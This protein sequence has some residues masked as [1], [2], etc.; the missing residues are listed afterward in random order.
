MKKHKQLQYNLL[1]SV[2]FFT[3]V[4]S[5]L[6]FTG[7]ESA[8]VDTPSHQTSSEKLPLNS[9]IFAPQTSTATS[10]V[11]KPALLQKKSLLSLKK[12][13]G[14]KLTKTI[15]RFLLAMFGVFLS[16]ITIFGFLKFYKFITGKNSTPF[17]KNNSK[18]SLESPKNFKEAINLFLD[19][20][21]KY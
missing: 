18:K 16:V 20:T 8:A 17:H 10:V 6:V 5:T 21:D 11:Q 1:Y 12:D 15:N 3:I 4:F 13:G 19:K 14:I 7:V 2:I 9:K